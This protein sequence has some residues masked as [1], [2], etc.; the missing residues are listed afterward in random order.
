MNLF[1]PGMEIETHNRVSASKVIKIDACMV[2]CYRTLYGDI[3]YVVLGRETEK[4][5]WLPVSREF[6]AA[7]SALNECDNLRA[8]IAED[9]TLY[10]VKNRAVLERE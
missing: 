9:K 10:T 2:Q 4:R 7:R 1:Y 8:Q 3:F 5:D 6:A